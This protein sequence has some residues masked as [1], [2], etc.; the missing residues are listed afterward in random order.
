MRIINKFKEYGLKGSVRTIYQKIIVGINKTIFSFFKVLPVRDNL[1][2]F[3]SEGDL[4]DNSFALFDYLVNHKSI[5]NY[6]F[7]WLVDD[8]KSCKNRTYTNTT[9]INKNS[10]G[11]D[12]KRELIL[13]RCKWCF[14]DHNNP[15]QGRKKRKKQK[16][17]FLDHGPAPFKTEKKETANLNLSKY[18]D[19]QINSSVMCKRAYV[20]HPELFGMW[21]APEEKIL[22][23]GESRDDYFYQDLS[24]IKEKISKKIS[25]KKFDKVF[26]WMPTFRQSIRP[27]LSENYLQDETKLPV[28]YTYSDLQSFNKFLKE[29]NCLV[30]LK[31]H[32]LQLKLPVFQ[33]QYS[34]IFFLRDSDLFNMNVQLSQ[35]I[36]L[37]DALITDYSSVMADYI[38]LNRPMIFTMDDYQEYKKSRGLYPDDILNYLPGP[39]VNN[40]K[41]L[42]DSLIE[43]KNDKDDFVEKRQQVLPYFQ[44]YQDGNT[45][46]RVADYFNLK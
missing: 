39:H 35:F 28:I 46:K 34:N 20:R 43:V 29:I 30:I 17:V 41:E 25:M 32:H 23:L 11:I 19:Y 2:V 42:K 10:R 36:P 1:I 22:L 4:S 12:F 9:Y 44:K 15:F 40:I 45:C 38:L 7:I 5:K 13:S 6:D 26:L 8:V 24:E 27:Q 31:V 14:F 3:E 16:V 33:K 37:S 21:G 18:Y